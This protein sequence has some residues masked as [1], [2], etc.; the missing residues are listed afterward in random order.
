VVPIRK[1]SQAIEKTKHMPNKTLNLGAKKGIPPPAEALEDERRAFVEYV[2]SV[3]A[4]LT[5]EVLGLIVE[6]V[7]REVYRKNPAL[8]KAS[9]RAPGTV[10]QKIFNLQPGAFERSVQIHGAL[11]RENDRTERLIAELRQAQAEFLAAAGAAL[12]KV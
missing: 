3:D 6:R 5:P 11:C 2:K 9:K 10:V 8:K 12:P 7:L 1:I 4:L